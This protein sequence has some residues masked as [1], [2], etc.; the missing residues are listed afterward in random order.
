MV[1]AAAVAIGLSLL[2]SVLGPSL[3]AS[4]PAGPLAAGFACS[5]L[6]VSLLTL[7]SNAEHAFFNP[8]YQ[9]GFFPE[10]E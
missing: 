6:F 10:G 3:A 2:L 7:V 5:L 9:A 4:E 1:T 8:D